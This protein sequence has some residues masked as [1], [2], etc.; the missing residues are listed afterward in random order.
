MNLNTF[1]FLLKY[2]VAKSSAFQAYLDGIRNQALSLEELNELNWSRTKSLLNY[3]YKN[4]PYYQ[5]KYKSVGL[6]P[7]DISSEKVYYQ[8][9]VLTKEEI[10]ENYELLISRLVS[11]KTVKDITTGGSTG[12]PLRVGRN[13][14][15][16][17]EAQKW[18]IQSW[19]G[20]NPTD[21]IA[22]AYRP[23]PY[24]N[25]DK[26][27]MRAIYYPQKAVKL[28]A[29]NI[30]SENIRS[31]VMQM[32]RIRPKMIHGYVGAIDAVADYII[33]HKIEVPAP[34]TVWLTAS[35]ITGIQESK[36]SSAF[37][38]PVCDQY[39]CSEVYFISA[40]CPKKEGL[41]VLSDVKKVEF[42]DKNNNGIGKLIV[43]DLEDYA[44]PLIRYMNGDESSFKDHKCSCGMNL[45]LMNKVKGRTTDNLE[46]GGDVVISGEYLTTIFDDYVD[47]VSRF[48]VIQ[49]SRAEITIKVVPKKQEGLEDV[50]SN[51][52][53]TLKAKSKGLADITVEVVN[54]IPDVKG[55][56]KFIIK[57]F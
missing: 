15:V 14:N 40:E 49:K 47:S 5:R 11:H 32:A 20:I 19:W 41:H 48:Q 8:V 38:A 6:H 44:F 36:I 28:D 54:R 1:Q 2:T 27:A 51:V 12:V 56:M 52:K 23:L 4:V 9:P 43:T 42:I 31:F 22:T 7:N 37:N 17:R 10:A 50:V 29:T 57:D 53:N 33:K 46:I 35:P 39:G 45:P 21:N 25:F 3:A 55:K 26:L 16:V 24:S 30:T 34:K 18:R 13:K